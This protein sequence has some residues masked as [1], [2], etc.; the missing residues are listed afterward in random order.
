MCLG[1]S[2]GEGGYWG[3]AVIPGVAGSAGAI[4]GE[5]AGNVGLLDLLFES[6]V[7]GLIVAPLKK[8]E[9]DD[10]LGERGVRGLGPSELWAPGVSGDEIFASACRV[11]VL[12]SKFGTVDCLVGILSVNRGSAGDPEKLNRERGLG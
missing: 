11:E 8:G 5:V 2:F 6:C 9:L 3:I 12:R 7:T 1:V 4:P 10:D